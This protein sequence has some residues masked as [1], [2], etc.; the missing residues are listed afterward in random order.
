MIGTEHSL[1]SRLLHSVLFAA[2]ALFGPGPFAQL[3]LAD[4][5][6]PF[7]PAKATEWRSGNGGLAANTAPGGGGLVF[8]CNA[9][10]GERTHWDLPIDLNLSETDLVEMDCESTP[11]G[12]FSAVHFYL[13][14]GDGWYVW[15][16]RIGEAGRQT[17]YF[18]PSQASSEGKPKGW[19]SIS[20]L[21]LSLTRG[22]DATGSLAV[23]GLRATKCRVAI[24]RA[25]ES[26][27]KPGE[28]AAARS[29][30]SRVSRWLFD[31]GVA[32]RVLDES[33][34]VDGGLE[35]MSL[36]ILPY[37]PSVP[38]RLLR[39]LRRFVNDGGRLMVC[40]SSDAALASLMRMELGPYLAA[41]QPGQWSQIC[42]NREAPA[43][44]P[45][46]VEQ[47]SRNLRIVRPLP[48]NSRVIAWWADASGKIGH[49]PAWLRSDI[50]VWMTH[51]LQD[52]DEWNKKRMLAALLGAFEPD[53][54][55]VNA[56]R[57]AGRAVKIGPYGD[58]SSARA[59]LTEAAAAGTE[60]PVRERLARAGALERIMYEALRGRRYIE[61]IETAGTIRTLLAEAYAM[62]QRPN[63]VSFRG[64]WNHSG[65][66]LYSGDWPRTCRELKAAGISAVFPNVL[67]AGQAHYPSRHVPLSDIGRLYG[68]QL[69]AC[70]AAA[71]AEGMEV[72]AWK[73]CWNLGQAPAAHVKQLKKEGR[74]QIAADQTTL[75]WLCPSN[76][77]NV[78]QELNAI[79]ELVR[80][81][82]VD[83]VHL[84][85]MRFPDSRSCCCPVCRECF[86]T[87]LGRRVR[88]WPGDATTGDLAGEYR[89]WR[90]TV[91]TDFVRTVRNEM[92]RIKPGVKLSVAVY[93]L[94][95]ECAGTMGQDWGRWLEEGL[96]DFVC[97]MD[98]DTDLASFNASIRKQLALPRAQGRIYPG[99]GVTAIESRLSP[100]QVIAQIRAVASA[101]GAGFMLFDLNPTL[102][103]ETLP[104]LRLGITRSE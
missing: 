83:G 45:S 12:V 59:I 13:R 15:R 31:M 62:A 68:D 20:G 22:A 19:D 28:Q 64:V 60:G 11:S 10:I 86:E 103:H 71:H 9:A 39:A 46:D 41:S 52:G 4:A 99:I 25:G 7:A 90:R 17:L 91:I 35:N 36:A 70:A 88:R 58:L 72:H 29:A 69:K 57:A 101:G 61:V 78:R 51:I 94:Y 1:F 44:V 43:G 97:P 18:Q 102:Q 82:P 40:Y 5:V 80:K 77:D 30:C 92:R 87:A 47:E 24:L 95:P 26:A 73:V 63:P 49:D 84:D 96:V 93:G 14:S 67:W 27:G 37:N 2:V 104:I 8:R 42:F 74:L 76:P 50:G 48:P 89:A 38:G 16:G 79:V 34:V 65:M 56:R 75:N 81:Y 100:D 53:I 32:N 98:Y 54:L 66:G 21:R 3:A 6:N 85:Y 33:A 55:H 23:Y